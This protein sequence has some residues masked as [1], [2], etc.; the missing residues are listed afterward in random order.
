MGW[1]F[2]VVWIW[3]LVLGYEMIYMALSRL[4]GIPMDGNSMGIFASC[5]RLWDCRTEIAFARFTRILTVSCDW[6]LI[7]I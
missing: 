3:L 6:Y 2:D 4:A 7:L 5:V 1:V